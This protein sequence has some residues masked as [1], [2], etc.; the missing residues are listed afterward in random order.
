MLLVVALAGCEAASPVPPRVV[1]HTNVNVHTVVVALDS[2]TTT[3]TI[4]GGPTPCD[5]QVGGVICT[6]VGIP[7]VADFAPEGLPRTQSAL[8]LPDDVTFNAVDGRLYVID[9]N[10]HRIRT[11]EPDG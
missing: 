10:N 11:V 4:P 3:V 2:T 8:Y 7:H 1:T 5:L 9:F 6:Y